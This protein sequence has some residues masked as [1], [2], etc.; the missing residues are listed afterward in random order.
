M[1]PIPPGSTVTT[2][3]LPIDGMLALL[4]LATM[5]SISVIFVMMLWSLF[6]LSRLDPHAGWARHTGVA[7]THHRSVNRSGG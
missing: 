7:A 3:S 5:A 6:D 1:N 4:L 2:T